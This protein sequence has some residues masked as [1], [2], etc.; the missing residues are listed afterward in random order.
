MLKYKN[1]VDWCNQRAC[2]GCWGLQEAV[3]CLHILN[4]IGE[5]PILKRKKKWLELEPVANEIVTETNKKI[6]EILGETD[7]R[8]RT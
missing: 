6:K 5:T 7:D 8:K 2:D 3:I 1:F 4:E